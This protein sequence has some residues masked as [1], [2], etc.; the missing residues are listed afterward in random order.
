MTSTVR[1]RFWIETVLA[2]ASA[3]LGVMTVFWRDWI[4]LLTGLDL[5]RQSGGLEWGIAVALLGAAFAAAAVA[6]AELR[7]AS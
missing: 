1:A 7:R 5:D 2:A 6:R 4:E 3:V